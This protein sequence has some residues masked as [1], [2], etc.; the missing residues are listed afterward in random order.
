[1]N[2]KYAK[3]A[4]AMAGIMLMTVALLPL[5]ATE[6]VAAKWF[7]SKEKQA[8][9]A[10]VEDETTGE[11]EAVPAYKVIDSQ[12]PDIK[13]VEEAIVVKANGEEEQ[14]AV[15]EA[16]D[17]PVNVD[18]VSAEELNSLQKQ[19]DADQKVWL[20]DPV[21]V[22]KNSADR[23]GFNDK[24][25]TFTL[26]SA[27]RTAG[28]AKVL[29]GHGDKYYLVQLKQPAGIGSKRIWQ[30]VSIQQVK[31]VIK[32]PST[33]GG[34]VDVGPGVEGLDYDKVIKWQQAV[35]AGRD[36]WRLNPLEVARQE[37]KSYGFSDQDM[38]TII[39]QYS[40][41]TLARHG[42]IDMEV[43]H[44]GRVYTM[45]LVKPLGGGD[46]IWTIYKV[47]GPVVPA[48]Q[49]PVAGEKILYS[50][51]KYAAWQWY[52]DRYL[53]DMS[54]KAIVTSGDIKEND[55]LAEKL[56]TIDFRNKLVLAAYLGSAGG[57][58]DIG[59]EKVVLQGN[60]LT[61]QVH[62]KSP[63]PDEM[64]TKNITFPADYVVLDRQIADIWGG[65]NVTFIDQKGTTLQKM[66][67]TIRH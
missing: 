57:G 3:I 4:A 32:K 7:G 42:Q 34:K 29:V 49:P 62:T 50:T 46:A 12:D 36:R 60:H 65:L 15:V 10:Q 24:E 52:S 19:V 21:L 26:L 47:T 58:Y 54:F 35:D 9:I 14:I 33:G 31:A 44:E 5:A 18:M 1:M 20:L 13:A 45:I 53:K 8:G 67:I 23:Y 48:P 39:R 63:R 28:I 66:K 43:K 11:E 27:D 6:V 41:T 16:A 40:G 51:N 38:F 2:K 61:V 22:L 30:V 17:Q 56:K 55:V 64:T 25:D 37:G 59:I